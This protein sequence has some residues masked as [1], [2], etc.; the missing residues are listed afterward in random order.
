MTH[1]CIL[2]TQIKLFHY[3]HIINIFKQWSYRKNYFGL[4]MS[5][6]MY[7]CLTKN[8]LLSVQI[9]NKASRKYYEQKLFKPLLPCSKCKYWV[10]YCWEALLSL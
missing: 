8:I 10:K 1:A 5:N 4:K 7:L 3:H 9:K 2:I 6:K